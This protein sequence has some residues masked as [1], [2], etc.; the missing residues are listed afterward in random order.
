MVQN[1]ARGEHGSQSVALFSTALANDQHDQRLMT[2][3]QW[4]MAND[5]LPNHRISWGEVSSLSGPRLWK[6]CVLTNTSSSWN[7]DA[8]GRM[9]LLRTCASSAVWTANFAIWSTSSCRDERALYNVRPGSRSLSSPLI[10]LSETS[11]ARS[12]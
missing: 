8:Q 6:K 4:P 12:A 9:A 10:R 1:C 3:D 7:D 5:Q 2:S 11:F